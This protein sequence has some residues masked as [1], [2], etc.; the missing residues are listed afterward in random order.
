MLQPA[1][2]GAAAA[3]HNAVGRLEALVLGQK[4]SAERTSPARRDNIAVVLV[5]NA[6]DRRDKGFC[7]VIAHKTDPCGHVMQQ[8]MVAGSNR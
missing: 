6:L 3:P 2:V 4:S 5:N 7:P 1:P 8:T